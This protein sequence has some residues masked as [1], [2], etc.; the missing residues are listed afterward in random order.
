MNS[1]AKKLRDNSIKVSFERY[2]YQILMTHSQRSDIE[3]TTLFRKLAISK[4]H[5][6]VFCGQ[7]NILKMPSQN[8][9]EMTSGHFWAM[10]QV[11]VSISGITSHV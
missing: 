8:I 11:P 9:V 7:H 4:I 5:D 3:T 2:D 6:L 10:R 1:N